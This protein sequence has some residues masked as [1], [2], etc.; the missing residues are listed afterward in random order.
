MPRR[1]FVIAEA[2]STHDGSLDLALELVGIAA[3]AGADACK[4]QFW[5]NADR[6]ADRRKVGPEYREIYRRYQVPQKWLPILRSE[7]VR[8]G[9]EFM[10]TTFLPEDIQIVAPFVERFKIASFEAGDQQFLEAH[11]RFA[12]PVILSTGMMDWGEAFR[13]ANTLHHCEAVLHC[14]SAYPCREPN[15]AAIR[16]LG[17]ICK[18]GFSDHTGDVRTGGLAVMAGA[19]VIEVHFSSLNTDPNNPDNAPA[20]HGGCFEGGLADYISHIRYAEECIGSGEK[21][22]LQEEA[23]MAEYRVAT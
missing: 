4:F 9:L 22:A 17:E 13:A 18:P 19:E 11:N 14:V 20:V 3:D 1:T 2:A 15:L 23:E 5:S 21:A 12:K 8:L 16:Q 7:C 10:C 6:L